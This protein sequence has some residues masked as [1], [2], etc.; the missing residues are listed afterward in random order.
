MTD[1]CKHPLLALAPM[2]GLSELPF[3]LLCRRYGADMCW[4]PMFHADR[5]TTDQKYRK[6]ALLTC[7]E[8]HPLVIQF[9]SNCAATFVSAAL[10]AESVVDAIEL[11]LGCPQREARLGHFGCWLLE[12]EDWPLVLEMV[13]SASEACTKPIYVKIRLCRTLEDTLELVSALEQAG[14]KLITVHGRM[15]A[16][17]NECRDGPADLS[18]IAAVKRTVTIPVL[19]NGNVC[20]AV[21]VLANLQL[22]G[23]DGVMVAEAA[24]KNPALFMSARTNLAENS[25]KS[26][27]AAPV[28]ARPRSH[29]HFC[30]QAYCGS[31]KT[32]LEV[33]GDY[34]NI[35]D[36]LI[37]QGMGASVVPAHVGKHLA[38][39][40]AG[41]QSHDRSGEEW[42]PWPGEGQEGALE[43]DAELESKGAE[44]GR[45]LRSICTGA[46]RKRRCL[47]QLKARL[48]QFREA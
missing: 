12:R 41:G 42:Q 44:I 9:A 13:R 45:Q 40:L 7:D 30:N 17:E 34:L 19:S 38:H 27:P 24:L 28:S 18:A 8:D 3:R 14:A 5:F 20:N 25:G 2:V 33:C 22:T 43:A 46:K 36:A 31:V 29:A 15:R 1:G 47:G 23:A 32:P 10:L 39:F 4:T 11:N 16:I 21:H 26:A 37:E 6:S 48:E 35:C